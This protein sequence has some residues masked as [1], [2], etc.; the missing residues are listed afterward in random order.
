VAVDLRRAADDITIR[1]SDTGPGIAPADRTR[2]FDR[3]VQLDAARRANG[4]G[5]GLSIAKW[6]TE[7]HGGTLVLETSGSTGSTF[8][9]SLPA[10]SALTGPVG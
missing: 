2:I 10:Q 5:L 7:A 9:I 3:F 8:R 1:V 4:T 6:I